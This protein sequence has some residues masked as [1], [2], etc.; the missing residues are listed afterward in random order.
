MTDILFLQL[1]DEDMSYDN[2]KKITNKTC[3]FCNSD[4]SKEFTTYVYNKNIA[5]NSCIFCHIVNN[6]KK[7][8][9]GCVFMVVSNMTQL[10]IN[11]EY[12]IYYDKND[13][14]A[15]P[16]KIDSSC[17]YIAVNILKYALLDI[18]VKKSKLFSKFKIMFTSNCYKKLYIKNVFTGKSKVP[19]YNDLSYIDIEEYK[20]NDDQLKIIN[21]CDDDEIKLIKNI[22]D[23]IKNEIKNVDKYKRL[24]IILTS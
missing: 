3:Y 19:I 14:I 1:Y 22:S 5:V 16:K 2:F 15:L 20:L 13:G 9:M 17:K 6:F 4:I 10:E 24:K 11:N 8:F 21:K 23:S 12:N 7:E 18:D